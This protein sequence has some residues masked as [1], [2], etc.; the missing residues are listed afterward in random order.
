MVVQDYQLNAR[1]TTRRARSSLAHLEPFF[2]E[3]PAT[4]IGPLTADYVAHRLGEGA[5]AGT[6]KVELMILSRGFSLAVQAGLLKY[7]PP[8][9]RLRVSNVR[10]YV[11]GPE[12]A[13]A[14][15]GYLPPDER[16]VA[17]MAYLLGWRTSEIVGLRWEN[18]DLA[19]RVITLDPGTTKNG[20]G[21]TLPYGRFPQLAA[22]IER[23]RRKTVE[24]EARL[25]CKIPSVFHRRGQS[26]R[27]IRYAWERACERAC[28]RLGLEE[29]P[30][31][32]DWRRVA[33]RNLV[34]AGVPIKVAM[35]ILGHKTRSMFDRYHI[36]V[37]DDIQEG[38]A[39]YSVRLFNTRSNGRG[40]GTGER[41]GMSDT[42]SNGHGK[43]GQRGGE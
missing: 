19:A 27:G 40:A 6:V 43:S 23:R 34:R 16:D 14:I 9:A 11:I 20:E 2:A 4:K 35:E 32:H 37:E 17:E 18:V 5:A 42:R 26:I 3:T 25:G 13:D 39:R 7:R 31:F 36:V 21:R 1:R 8:I 10:K 30:V 33:A 22:L 29:S 38:L 41:Q 24:L 15:L 28:E 12:L